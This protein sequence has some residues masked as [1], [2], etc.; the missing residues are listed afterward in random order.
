MKI[1]VKKLNVF[2][3]SDA[4]FAAAV[5]AA[6][7][8]L[9]ARCKHP[10]LMGKA[11][12]TEGGLNS[13]RKHMEEDGIVILSANRSEVESSDHRL[14]LRP[15]YDEWLGDSEDTEAAQREFLKEYNEEQDAA[16]HQLLKGQNFAF[17]KVYGGYRG[18]D[19]VEDTYEPSY[20]VYPYKKTSSGRKGEP[21]EF[22]QLVDF[23]KAVC[24]K[25][26]QDSV[27]VQYPGEAPI[28]IDDQGSKVSGRS[29]KQMRFN[30]KDANF[31]TT[32]KRSKGASR[33]TADISAS[34]F[35]ESFD[36]RPIYVKPCERIERFQRWAEGEW[37]FT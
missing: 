9:R 18:K 23:A 5:E 7:A 4:E 25:F 26:K 2:R 32:T 14:D 30:D 35:P 24:G 15:Q 3:S 34:E 11:K 16:L 28:W 17:S 33:F 12:I 37:L 10:G 31:F 6:A 36:A 13:L 27:Y 1:E 29:S 19:G 22:S 20:I 21:I 8:R